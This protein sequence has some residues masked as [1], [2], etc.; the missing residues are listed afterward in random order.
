MK[1]LKHIKLFEDFQSIAVSG[2]YD[3][4]AQGSFGRWK[5]ENPSIEMEEETKTS[6]SSIIKTLIEDFKKEYN[7][8]IFDINNGL[9]I[10]FSEELINRLG[11]YNDNNSLYEIGTDSFFTDDKDIAKIWN[12]VI[13]TPFGY[14]NKNMLDKFGLPPIALD[15]IYDLPH[16]QWVFYNGKF[17]DADCLNGVTKWV[18]L[19]L[20]KKIFKKD[21]KY[22][23]NKSTNKL[24]KKKL[25]LKMPEIGKYGER[26]YI[27]EEKN[28]G[29]LY[30]FTSLINTFLIIQSNTLSSYR[31]IHNDD[32][33]VLGKGGK[34]Y[35]YTY[36]FTRNKNLSKSIHDHQIDTTLSCRITF[37]GNKL[38]HKFKLIPYNWMWEYDKNLKNG[39]DVN[40]NG[41]IVNMP[42]PHS[43]HIGKDE[44]EE[45]IVY[46][47]NHIDDIKSYILNIDLCSFDQFKIEMDRYQTV[48]NFYDTLGNLI[49]YFN[50]NQ[51]N[52]EEDED[53]EITEEL[54]RNLYD[55]LIEY[56]NSHK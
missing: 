38:S 24:Y 3:T 15:K 13:T 41:K 26:N 51:D 17:Y 9:C 19:P 34:E 7:C 20:I 35:Y 27:K 54:M 53:G 44:S 50:L 23:E 14:W 8:T 30:H 25:N 43:K 6:I 49:Q 21:I 37:D 11:G 22:S 45:V 28:I 47:K 46:H 52:D 42:L 18:D 56:I 40:K 36:S 39:V 55:C 10:E 31:E 1:Y 16:H 5:N 33:F 4:G 12:N 2:L 29:L 48:D 32:K